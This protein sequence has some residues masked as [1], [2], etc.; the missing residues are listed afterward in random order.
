MGILTNGS[1]LTIINN[2]FTN[3]YIGINLTNYL[4]K[5]GNYFRINDILIENNTIFNNT[6]FGLAIGYQSDCNFTNLTISNNKI[7]NN[8]F[9]Y[10]YGGVMIGSDNPQNLLHNLKIFNNT[11]SNQL[12]GLSIG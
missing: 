5:Y 8:G 9:G 11:F 2:T 4:F 10:R 12:Y 7:S 1:K 6:L 3:N